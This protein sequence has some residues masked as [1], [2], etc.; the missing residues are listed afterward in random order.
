MLSQKVCEEIW[1]CQREIATAE[2]LLEELKAL[3]N[4]NKE[5]RFANQHEERLKDIFGRDGDLELGV[6]T[7]ERSKRLFRVSYEL[8]VPVINAHIANKAAALAE[9]NEM[10]KL[11]LEV[12]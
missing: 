5:N 9:L 2:K 7:G 11:E 4:K 6:P 8:A 1:Q 10:A 3:I 12:G